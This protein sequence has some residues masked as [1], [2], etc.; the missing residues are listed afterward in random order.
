MRL[1]VAIMEIGMARLII[2]VEP[3]RRRKRN[4]TIMAKSA[5]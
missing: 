1:K 3:I 5:P 4:R 2:S